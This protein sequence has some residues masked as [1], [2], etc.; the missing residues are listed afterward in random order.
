[1]IITTHAERKALALQASSGRQ[2]AYM[3]AFA[4]IADKDSYRA[5]P[6]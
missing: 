3:T 4:A 2:I 1:M 6:M 5:H